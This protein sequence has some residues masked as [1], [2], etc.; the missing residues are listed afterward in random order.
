QRE[1]GKEKVLGGLAHI[2]ATLDE[3]GG[4][5]HTG[6][7][8]VL[9]FGTLEPEQAAI[10]QQLEALSSAANM[11][12]VYSGAITSELWKK[13]MFINAFSGITTAANL[14]IGPVREHQAT[15][16][17]A[18]RMLEEM[19]QLANAYGTPLDDADVQ[20]AKDPL[21][22]LDQ[23]ATSSMHQDRRQGLMLEVEHLHG[24]A[25]RMA[26]EKGCDLPFIEAVY[27]LIK[28]FERP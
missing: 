26:E 4:V 3:K 22:G 20:V 5:K 27:G 12:A 18:E 23:D 21:L 15:F 9:T 25:L 19:R 14:P 16:K 10:C 24:G 17:A 6:H 2:M 28:P 11:D 1:L 8:H 13:Y 7:F